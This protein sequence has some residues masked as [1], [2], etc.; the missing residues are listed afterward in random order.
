[1]R[2]STSP[3]KVSLV[4]FPG[5]VLRVLRAP[6]QPKGVRVL[7]RSSP[8]EASGHAL[9]HVPGRLIAARPVG[10]G[11]RGA[12][13]H[14]RAASA[15]SGFFDKWGEEQAV[16]CTG[17][18]LSGLGSEFCNFHSASLTGGDCKLQSL[19]RN[20]PAGQD[21]QVRTVPAVAWI[22]G[23]CHPRGPARPS[24]HERVPVL[25]GST[26]LGPPASPHTEGIGHT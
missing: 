13:A 21:S 14:A 1:M 5:G 16:H 12:D 3:Q 8:A 4:H 22:D 23:V 18:V 9:R 25:G 7:Y 11:S 6:F 26:R 15:G 2:I 17:H 19:P 10:A 20:L 24:P